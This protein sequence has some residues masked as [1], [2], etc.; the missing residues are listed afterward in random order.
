[1]PTIS[2]LT[3]EEAAA[4]GAVPSGPPPTP[5]QLRAMLHRLAGADRRGLTRIDRAGEHAWRGRV[6]TRSVEIHKQFSDSR[7][8]GPEGALRAALAWRDHARKLAGAQQE[9]SAPSVRVVRAEGRRN[10]G[11]L[12]YTPRGRRYFADGKHGGVEGARR[13][14]EEWIGQEEDAVIV[15][16]RAV[17][18]K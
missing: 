17:E 2:K 18:G 11:W 15:G 3:P 4:W 9:R 16:N 7:Y 6:Y 12:A 1:M 5:A 8:G 10:C 13:A 14:A